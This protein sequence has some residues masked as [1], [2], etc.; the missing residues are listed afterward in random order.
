MNCF[1]SSD[2]FQVSKDSRSLATQITQA[3]K[4]QEKVK[5]ELQSLQLTQ[6]AKLFIE[7][8][9]AEGTAYASLF[10]LSQRMQTSLR[11]GI[12]QEWQRH[13]DLQEDL[14]QSPPQSI[15]E[16]RD[17]LQESTKQIAPW[18]LIG[19]GQVVFLTH[20]YR[21]LH[22]HSFLS[23]PAHH[24]STFKQ[25]SACQPRP[26]KVW[27]PQQVLFLFRNWFACFIVQQ[28]STKPRTLET[29]NIDS[30]T[31]FRQEWQQK[32]VACN[33]LL[34]FGARIRRVELQGPAFSRTLSPDFQ[35]C[36]GNRG[37]FSSKTLLWKSVPNLGRAW[38][39]RSPNSGGRG[40][41]TPSL[42]TWPLPPAPA[43][44]PQ[45]QNPNWDCGFWILYLNL[46]F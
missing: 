27:H 23:T 3:K 43:R 41:H 26:G 35:T 7:S 33:L 30:S 37:S 5:Q 39:E 42:A 20:C 44:P 6:M 46:G 32:T 9:K 36:L 10:E 18:R 12:S 40:G 31:L 1:R 19:Q 24:S 8:M 34:S 21:T 17:K 28:P 22:I 4:A 13:Y 38:R 45:I 16:V 15:T 25:A 2:R 29:T 14:R 11:P